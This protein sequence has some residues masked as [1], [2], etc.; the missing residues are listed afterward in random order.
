VGSLGED[1]AWQLPVRSTARAA[2][3]ERLERP[4]EALE[5]WRYSP[6]DE[7]QWDRYQG[8][9]IA[10]DAALWSRAT[11]M[12]AT[13]G[14]MDAVI[15]I[16]GGHLVD[17]DSH[18]DGVTAV[19]VQATGEFLRQAD[20][21]LLSLTTLLA[22]GRLEVNLDTSVHRIGIITCGS[23]AD[24][25]LWSWLRMSVAPGASVEIIQIDLLSGSVLH[26]PV[27]E[28][29][30]GEKA[31]VTYR[32]Q[33][34]HDQRALSLG[35]VR[36]RLGADARLEIDTASTHQGYTRVRTDGTLQG[37]RASAV[38]RVGYVVGTAER[39]DYRTF[40][41]HDAPRT[42][43]DLLYK[44]VVNGDG[45]SIYTGTITITPLGGGSEA[46]QTNRNVLLSEE[47]L[48]WSVPN[49]DIQISDVK[50]SHASTV[51]PIDE[52]QLFYLA[53][54]GFP[55]EEARR[56]LARA[57]FADMGDDFAVEQRSLRAAVDEKWEAGQ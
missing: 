14:P 52:E 23:G 19:E 46:F 20:E 40:I 7:V 5:C 2:E 54:K 11:E 25:G 48:A 35:Y 6:I 49:L 43:S 56:T 10:S 29:V 50:C 13:F 3:M 42:K 36:F 18:S 45:N 33:L 41:T 9:G 53:S 16:D 17:I 28:I 44:G 15:R 47:A 8:S 1:V 21:S 30:G 24:A 34:D 55:A 51:G 12:L 39:V 4:T 32:Q 38:I 22:P 57:F 31:S 37:A 27:I 26:A